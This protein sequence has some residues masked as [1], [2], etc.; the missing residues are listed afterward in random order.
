M[1]RD[2]AKE[3]IKENWK[4]LYPAAADGKGI[5]CPL[6]GHGT[7]GDGIV[8]NPKSEDPNGLKCFGCGF[9]GDVLSLVQ[10]EMNMDYSEALQYAADQLYITIE[11]TPYNPP[12]EPRKVQEVQ[13]PTQAQE[14]QEEPAQADYTEYYKACRERLADPRAVS[15]LQ[16]RG[17]SIET[18]T[19]YWLGFDPAADPANA[20]GA[21]DHA[22]KLH[23]APR[24]IIPTNAAHYVGRAIDPATPGRYAKMNAKDST[25]GIFNERALYSG[26]PTVFVTEGVFDALSIIEAGAPAIAL[27]STANTGSFLKKMEKRPTTSTLILTFDQD[28]TGRRYTQPLREGLNRL[29]ISHIT[30]DICGDQG[31]PND[32]L[33]ADRAAFIEAVKR[34]QRR[35]GTK[36]DNTTLYI[37]Q[38]MG[39]DIERFAKAGD[40]KTGFSNLDAK[41]GGL[42][43][44]LYVLAATSSL[45]KTTFALQLA[46]QLA[47]AGH[48]VIFFSLEQSRLE[49]V[50]K[51]LA[52]TIA[53][54]DPN[55]RIDSLQIRR[56]FTKYNYEILDA[57]EDYKKSIGDR[58]SIIE[59]NFNCDLSF[60]GDYVRQYIRK[61]GEDHRPAIILDYLQILA[62]LK[63]DRGR[64]PST[65]EAVDAAV[66]G[67]KR[68]SR[69]LDLTVI[70]ISSVNRS[71]YMQP[72]DF[73][74]LKE[75]GGIEYG[76]DCV[77][78][79]QLSCLNEDL[80]SEEKGIKAKRERIRAAKTANPREIELVCLKNR[81]GI[82][83]FTC[84]FKYYPANDLFV[85]AD[86]A[87]PKQRPA[88]KRR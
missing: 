33:T 5:I 24:I 28:A 50:S 62:P 47:G 58:L 88:G 30:G 27:C 81:Y 35:A 40:R 13:E 14:K 80:F 42:Y 57:I 12:Q 55:T 11:N 48:D 66:T 23:P 16:G 78:G 84:N 54:A 68:M 2:Q 17:I 46:D 44:G 73:E 59:S 56:G 72:I 29:N 86:D 6:C 67:L 9:S 52:R 69:E 26:A 18:A 10:T 70:A 65:K 34:D 38:L 25:P 32:A 19:A 41:T 20:P 22:Q 74:S 45:G 36:P 76:A 31:D 61:N 51:S 87:E 53:Q 15:Y 77:L 39:E 79:L 85:A 3:F 63:D 8:R 64:T 37:D 75:S 49:L 60:I 82:S 83:S 1:N 71:N 21:D 43:S 7:H 4:M